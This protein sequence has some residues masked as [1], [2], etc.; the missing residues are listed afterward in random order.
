MAT[1]K[2]KKRESAMPRI[3]VSLS[4]EVH[5][6][7][8]QIAQEKKVSVAWVMRDAAEQYIADKWPLFKGKV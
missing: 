7:L 5:A 2:Q 3:S 1:G 4:P 8:E 6:T